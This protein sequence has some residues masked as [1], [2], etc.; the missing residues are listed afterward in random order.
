MKTRADIT[1]EISP[2][3]S[4]IIEYILRNIKND[5]L[6]TDYFSKLKKP[7][8][9]KILTMK[10]SSVHDESL[11]EGEY[12][13]LGYAGLYSKSYFQY[14]VQLATVDAID[15][16]LAEDPVNANSGAVLDVVLSANLNPPAILELIQKASSEVISHALTKDCLGWNPFFWALQRNDEIIACTLFKKA[17]RDALIQAVKM[18]YAGTNIINRITE[19]RYKQI[20]VDTLLE[21]LDVE[22]IDLMMLIPDPEGF[23]PLHQLLLDKDHKEE[24]EALIC[25]LV[26][27]TS[28]KILFEIA[29]QRFDK[30]VQLNLIAILIM[31][32]TS[33]N[34]I[35]AIF[36][37][38]DKKDINELMS[39]KAI[40][41]MMPLTFALGIKNKSEKKSIKSIF[42]L[43]PTNINVDVDPTIVA[44]AKYFDK[45]TLRSIMDNPRS[46]QQHLSSLKAMTPQTAVRDKKIKKIEKKIKK[47]G[48]SKEKDKEKFLNDCALNPPLLNELVEKMLLENEQVDLPMKALY[49][50]NRDNLVGYLAQHADLCIDT[51][52]NLRA[53]SIVFNWQYYPEFE[54]RLNE[55]NLILQQL[56]DFHIAAFREFNK[57][58][59]ESLAKVISHYLPVGLKDMGASEDNNEIV[60]NKALI[61]RIHDEIER[62]AKPP[63]IMD[64]ALPA[65]TSSFFGK[66]KAEVKTKPMECI[67][68]LEDSKKAIDDFIKTENEALEQKSENKLLKPRTLVQLKVFY[69]QKNNEKKLLQIEKLEKALEQANKEYRAESL[70]LMVQVFGTAS[71]KYLWT[72]IN[73]LYRARQLQNEAKQF[74]YECRETPHDGDCF[75]HAIVDQLALRGL[76]DLGTSPN[77]IR[78]H[79]VDYILT[80]LNDY[81]DFLD[82]HD[83]DI[84]DFISRNIDMGAWA[85]HLIISALSRALNINIVIIRSDGAAPTIFKQSH[86]ITTLY[87]GHE[88]GH[89]YQS[90]LENIV[91]PKAKILQ[92]YIDAATLDESV[93]VAM[94]SASNNNNS[95]MRMKIG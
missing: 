50:L 54:K 95:E 70:K 84:N 48:E 64:V 19:R 66:K 10:L 1:E 39:E 61:H 52:K 92:E 74:G 81:K 6:L 79:A 83:G 40:F 41:E 13:L 16:A 11:E 14:L 94:S 59:P 88:V 34:V 51:I 38:L 18:N 23:T 33:P 21:Q 49:S 26:S 58:L 17:G 43:A 76:P 29:K 31:R 27:H 12:N 47:Q 53:Y 90:L 85:D 60:Q 15:A 56:I 68:K 93:V 65:N 2:T 55:A 25:S 46:L 24:N 35:D 45:D 63:K 75:F 32:K 5:A 42:K 86:P 8:S 37:R 67:K 87:L 89:H 7:L 36:S 44:M 9:A 22:T 4:E 30:D 20:V 82:Q 78:A 91:L 28:P 72:G 62:V 57:H 3:D 80:H 77:E 71:K 73:G 69:Q